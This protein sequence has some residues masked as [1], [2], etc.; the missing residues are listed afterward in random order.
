MIFLTKKR[1]LTVTR[2][3]SATPATWLYVPGD[4]GYKMQKA[5]NLVVDALIL[6]LEDAVPAKSKTMARQTLMSHLS[7]LNELKRQPKIHVRINSPD[8][9]EGGADLEMLKH[10]TNYHG[11]RIPKVEDPNAI[12]RVQAVVGQRV[13][14]HCT[15]ETSA[16][17]ENIRDIVATPGVSGISL[18][19]VDLKKDLGVSA[20]GP[21]E[22]ARNR[23]IYA[24]AAAKLPPPPMPVYTD[25]ADLKGLAESCRQGKMNGF[26]GRA[27]LHPSQIQIIHTEFQP[28][29]REVQTARRI[30]EQAD[31]LGRE[32]FMMPN[33]TF[34]DKPILEAAK[35]TLGAFEKYLTVAQDRLLDATRQD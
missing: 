18:G 22:Y 25:I 30:V 6:D 4:S 17:L 15:I 23:L 7:Q 3:S 1:G 11:V 2:R 20:N 12:E 34:V 16:G 32:T 13:E 21:I 19:E 9:K 5:M 27:A 33:G 31:R 24:A 29:D 26:F 8:T 10:A 35:E 14:I 28:N